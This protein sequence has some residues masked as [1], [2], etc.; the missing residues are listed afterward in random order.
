M[1]ILYLTITLLF[2]TYFKS[3]GIND[4]TQIIKGQVID[5]YSKAPI[6][7]ATVELLN[8]QPT[9]RALTDAEGYFT[10]E[11]VPLGRHKLLVYKEFFE[12]LVINGLEV[13]GGRQVVLKLNLEESVII[14]PL[15]GIKTEK[16]AKNKIVRTTK[17]QPT[18]EMSLGSVRLFKVEEVSRFSGT[19][20][21]PIRQMDVYA[22]IS[23]QDDYNNNINIRGNSPQQFQWRVEGI[24]IPNPNH[25][26]TFG[27]TGGLF[28]I[29]NPN[30]MEESDVYL[31]AFTA[32]YGDA[33]AGVFDVKLHTGNKDRFQF[34]AQYSSAAGVQAMIEGPLSKNKGGS[35]SAAFRYGLYNYGNGGLEQILGNSYTP[36][37]ASPKY[38]DYTLNLDFPKTSIGTFSLFSIGG[39]AAVTLDGTNP[40]LAAQ[41]QNV[42]LYENSYCRTSVGVIGL[43]HKI[44]IGKARKGFVENVAGITYSGNEENTIWQEPGLEEQPL[45][46]QDNKQLSGTLLTTIRYKFNSKFMLKGGYLS[47]MHSI[48]LNESKDLGFTDEYKSKAQTLTGLG[49]LHVQLMYR[50]SKSLMINGGILTQYFH[51]SNSFT[52]PEPRFA[53][54]WNFSQNHALYLATGLYSQILPWQVYLYKN[55]KDEYVNKDLPPMQAFH[56]NIGYNWVI[57]KDWRL[58]LETYHQRFLSIPL[59]SVQE[60]HSLRNYGGATQ[61]MDYDNLT[62]DGTGLNTGVELTLEKFFSHGYYALLTGSFYT[63]SHRRGNERDLWRTPFGNGYKAN[64]LI[65]KEFLI[66]TQKHNRFNIGLRAQYKSGNYITPIDSTASLAAQRTIYQEELGYTEKLK[67]YVRL[68]FRLGFV[69]NSRKGHMS[70]HFFLDV[71]N[72]IDYE[73][74]SGKYFDRSS[75]SVKHYYQMPLSIDIM[76]QIRF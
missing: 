65:G 61:L 33:L 70:H 49:R 34:M 32:E 76:Y 73:N 71:L 37:K 60:Y 48:K 15:N 52:I 50:P 30:T 67:D 28:N 57:S 58:K 42:N 20:F 55:K 14:T 16:K 3:V 63:S 56:I 7:G 64:L 26:G 59:D 18:N 41:S 43:K 6:E 47:Q 31:G 24:S 8:F 22:G 39:F 53:I 17:D 40:V 45:H 5:L 1:R 68:D 23:V 44:Y 72:F 66:G 29:L 2:I 4:E 51:F 27:N 9:K 12:D 46:S 75:Q 25:L 62:S 54:N 69:F 35:F 10:M 36:A 19:R 13:T 21:D 11:E 38:W 74:V